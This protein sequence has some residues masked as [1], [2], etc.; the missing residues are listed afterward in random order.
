MFQA[1][2]VMLVQ[3]AMQVLIARGAKMATMETHFK[4]AIT[5]N[6]V[7]AM[8]MLIFMHQIG[9]TIFQENVWNALEIQGVGIV[10]NV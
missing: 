1:I 4:L 8:E 7:T 9:V 3:E 6:P 5:A 2:F 10:I